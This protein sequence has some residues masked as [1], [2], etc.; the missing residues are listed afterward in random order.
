[1]WPRDDIVLVLFAKHPERA[2]DALAPYLDA[3]VEVRHDGA[4][5]IGPL[6]MVALRTEPREIV[7]VNDR[8]QPQYRLTPPSV[9]ELLRR[10]YR[11][12]PFDPFPYPPIEGFDAL[13]M[14]EWPGRTIYANLPIRRS[15]ELHG[16]RIATILR[17][18]I[19]QHQAYGKTLLVPLPITAGANQLLRAGAQVRPL[20]RVPWIDTQS[21]K[22]WG[23]PI[24]CALFVL[25]GQKKQSEP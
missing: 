17:K 23:S 5:R 9:H 8:E 25:D 18:V 10:E 7:A 4:K 24:E 12:D 19:E 11:P 22:P 16:R 14:E 20:G 1:M 3:T 15:D 21:G 6:Q 13:A 2:L